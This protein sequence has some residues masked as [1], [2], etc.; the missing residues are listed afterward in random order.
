LDRLATIGS[1][2]AARDLGGRVDLWYGGTALF[3]KHP[4]LGVGS[5]AFDKAN[6]IGSVAH[7][8]FLSVLAELG[9][10]GFLLF[11]VILVVVVSQAVHHSKSNSLF[12]LTVLA[13]WAI[14]ISALTWEFRKPTWLF[15]SLVVISANLLHP[16]G[17]HQHLS[18]DAQ[19]TKTPISIGSS[20]N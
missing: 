1:S 16:Y 5:G 6:E 3:I 17:G 8:T 12:W 20:A 10:I 9:I 14:G 7:N 18:T 4:L 11:F 19:L 15:L 13:V 2:I